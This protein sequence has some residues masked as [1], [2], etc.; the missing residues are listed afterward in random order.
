MSV[1]VSGLGSGLDYDSWITQLVAAK[2][3]K[4]DAVS[5]QVKAISKKE[6]TLSS[7]KSDYTSLLSAV[8]SFTDTLTSSDVFN[9]KAAKSSSDSITVAAT[10]TADPQ[11]LKVSVSKLATA[12]VAQSASVAASYVD[13]SS[14]MSDI[15]EGAVTAGS[16]SLYVN[17]AKNTISITKDK[18]IDDVLTEMNNIAGVSASID[19]SGKL[20]IS[21]SGVGNTVTVGSSADTSNFSKVMSL[22]RNTTTGV[23]SSS[24]S[25]FDTNTTTPLVSSSF[26]GGTIKAGTFTIGTTSFTIDSSTT[27][28]G[29]L[30][31]INKS[32]AGVTATWDSNAGKLVLAADDQGAFNINISAGDGKVG[33]DDAS[34]FTDIMG[35]TTS[36]W[37]GDGKLAS[38]VLKTGSQSLGSN[39][40]LTINGTEITSS[41]NTVTSDISGIKGLTLTL[42]STTTADATVSVTQDTAKISDAITKLVSAY[43]KSI[44]DTD[45]ATASDGNLYG[46]SILTS[47]R[48]KVRTLIT[49]S[50]SGDN[51]Y[52]TL[53]S[54]GITTGAVSTDTK[55]NLKSTLTIDTDKLT[56]ALSEN[57][58]A[59]KTLLVGNSTS[60]TS[61]LL[62]KME[63][64]LENATNPL[65]G[66]FV[67]RNESY[68]NQTDRLDDKISSMTTA[69]AKYKTQLETKFQA[70]DST[71]ANLKKQSTIFDSYFNKTNS[72]S[73]S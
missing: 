15:A 55:A 8:Q 72:S 50:I 37:D 40:V 36:T 48:N 59:V 73:S 51:Q 33:D 57:S 58:D 14:K 30:D 23:Y 6:S 7:I 11:N 39:A 66:Y 44:T 4:I 63:T 61:G 2:Q 49:S 31:K 1:T 43:N 22:T 53:A 45:S 35:L 42:N 28:K 56:S 9:Q 17:G 20:S 18:T 13:G 19:S 67:K 71:I 70:M 65:K 21:S 47:L 46:E 29:L 27:L 38:T 54:I 10:S 52:K 16:F 32:D 62:S 60:G 12:T 25:I 34:N 68:Q 69:M 26:A 64:V 41:S 24:K 3:S 5:A